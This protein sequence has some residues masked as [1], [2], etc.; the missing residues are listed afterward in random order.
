MAGCLSLNFI[1]T[2]RSRDKA[3]FVRGLLDYGDLIAWGQTAGALD[4]ATGTH[5]L[6]ESDARPKDAQRTFQTTIDLREALYCIF[7]DLA[8][9]LSPNN[10]DLKVLNDIL[11]RANARSIVVPDGETFRWKWDATD[12]PLERVLWAVA[13]AAGD[14]ITSAQLQWIK[15]CEAGCGWLFLDTS[16][17][18][19]RRWCVMS[20]CGNR[21]K[22]RRHHRRTKGTGQS[23]NGRPSEVTH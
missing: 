12:I 7:R 3:G 17:N 11:K 16:K 14:L 9:K 13:R 4:K 2:V 15:E 22:A 20:I 6:S 23:A 5:L 18:H 21:A 19:S 10:R 8:R 1:N